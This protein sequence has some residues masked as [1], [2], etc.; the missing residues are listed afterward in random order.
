MTI[1]FDKIQ[2]I[3]KALEAYRGDGR[4]ALLFDGRDRGNYGN[5]HWGVLPA[6][7]KRPIPLGWRWA[8][9]WPR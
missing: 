7:S 5:Y 8:C 3:A 2:R 9:Y 6:C 1:S 4:G